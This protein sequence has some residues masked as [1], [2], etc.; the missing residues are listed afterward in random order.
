MSNPS[1]KKE[2]LSRKLRQRRII[3][4]SIA[5]LFVAAVIGFFGVQLALNAAQ[6]QSAAQAK[7]LQFEKVKAD[8]QDTWCATYG[9]DPT[10]IGLDEWR[11]WADRNRVYLANNVN[12][13]GF[14]YTQTNLDGS[15]YA[16]LFI[17]E[18]IRDANYFTQ[19]DFWFQSGLSNYFY[20]FEFEEGYGSPPSC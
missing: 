19:A 10:N 20:A 14:G 17:D 4:F 9:V 8:F 7:E 16:V 6:A 13:L 18:V 5:G 1:K 11:G 2:F 15:Q 3:S 12:E